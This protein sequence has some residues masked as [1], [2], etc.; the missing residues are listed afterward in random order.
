MYL[1]VIYLK[2]LSASNG[3]NNKLETTW[4][5]EGEQAEFKILFL[6]LLER[7]SITEAVRVQAEFRT[8]NLPNTTRSLTALCFIALS[9]ACFDMAESATHFIIPR[10]SLCRGM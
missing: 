5:E 6:H 10:P 8:G 7:L 9:V 4:K 3:L 1:F 2:N